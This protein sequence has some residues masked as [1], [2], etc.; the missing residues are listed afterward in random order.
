MLNELVKKG[1]IIMQQIDRLFGGGFEEIV[2]VGECGVL[3]FYIEV[4]KRFNK[5]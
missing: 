5:F 4:R 2:V 3:S 1:E